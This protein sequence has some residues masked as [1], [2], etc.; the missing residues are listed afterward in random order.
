MECVPVVL[1]VLVRFNLHKGL[2]YSIKLL[3]CMQEI[4]LKKKQGHC[5][6]EEP[7]TGQNILRKTEVMILCLEK[8]LSLAARSAEQERCSEVQICNPII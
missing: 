4:V 8:S 7:A 3:D 5:I 2:C 6:N 1:L